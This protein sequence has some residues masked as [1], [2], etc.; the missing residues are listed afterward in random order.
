MIRKTLFAVMIL[1]IG[2]SPAFAEGTSKEEGAGLGFGAVIGG[3]AG[4][5]AGAI[6]GAAIGAKLGDSFHQKSEEVVTLSS[7][8]DESRS[9]ISGLEQNIVALKGEVRNKDGQLQRTRELARP[10]VLALLQ[11]GI[12]MDLLFR[13]DEHVLA[14]DTGE[15]LRQLASSLAANPDIRIQLDG[16]ADERGNAEY[17]QRLSGKRAGH[18]RD[19]LVAN[20]VPA[21]RIT[22]NAHGEAPATEQ[23]VDSFA[24]E[25]R[26]SLTLYLGDAPAVAS[27]TN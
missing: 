4:G 18:V 24:L 11:T 5:P 16:F 7:S 27:N 3:V 15:R 23:N 9:T 13:T 26:V 10:E 2:A 14:D 8:L 19:L 22:V 20:G 6:I 17:N 1:S 12:E 21:D 25:R